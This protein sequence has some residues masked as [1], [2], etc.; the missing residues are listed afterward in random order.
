MTKQVLKVTL[1]AALAAMLLFVTPVQAEQDKAARRAA[2]L[3][4]KMQADMQAQLEA[5]K[6]AFEQEKQAM[7]AE[8]AEQQ[9]TIDDYKAKSSRLAQNKRTLTKEKAALEQQNKTTNTA[10]EAA[11]SQIETL[12]TKLKKTE[13]ALAF[14]QKQRKTILSNLSESNQSLATCEARNQKLYAY[15][16]ELIDFYES[17][18]AVK[19]VKDKASFL[20]SKRVVLDNLLQSEQDLLDE[21]RFEF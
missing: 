3:M 15:G 4:R 18:K 19:A 17:P 2:Q 11:Q 8:I 13:S 9:V 6:T 16:S 20:Q 1:G 21:N 10:L 12:T 14:S 7:A 5:Q